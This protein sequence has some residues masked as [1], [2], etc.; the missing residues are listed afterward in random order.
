MPSRSQ[1]RPV[2]PGQLIVDRDATLAGDLDQRPLRR[3]LSNAAGLTD[4]H[5]RE[6]VDVAEQLRL[7]EGL[8]PEHESV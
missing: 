6:L 7:S 3:L 5:L 1:F 8:T 4:Q 2:H